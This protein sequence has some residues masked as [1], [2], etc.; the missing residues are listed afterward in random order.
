MKTVTYLIFLCFYFHI[1]TSLTPG[2]IK[3]EYEFG[4]AKLGLR[5]SLALDSM[6]LIENKILKQFE[7][8]GQ[9]LKFDYK[10]YCFSNPIEHKEFPKLGKN[11]LN[12]IYKYLK[13]AITYNNA[14][15]LKGCVV[16][17][18]K[19]SKNFKSYVSV[20]RISR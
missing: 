15:I 17:S 6:I 1:S 7:G 12:S 13:K 10:V 4:K 16:L 19:E 3:V 2:G 14:K 9:N 11:R 18:D 20:Q 5:E 8:D